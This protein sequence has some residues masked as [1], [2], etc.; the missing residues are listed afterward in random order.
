MPPADVPL[1]PNLL[2]LYTA[3][4]EKAG[5]IVPIAQLESI[6]GGKNPRRLLYPQMTRMRRCGIPVENIKG[7]GYRLLKRKKA[8]KLNIQNNGRSME[9]A[10]DIEHVI[11]SVMQ[12][13]SEDVGFETQISIMGITIGAMLHQLPR[14]E[15]EH[16]TKILL[17][18]IKHA[19][20]MSVPLTMQ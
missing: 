6:V 11:H 15:R 7:I 17:K 13:Y 2:R 20:E 12:H 4:H 8:R 18:A 19:D 5:E 3:L 10:N 16:F 1:T 9:Y 14:R